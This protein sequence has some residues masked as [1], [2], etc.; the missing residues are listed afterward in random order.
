[1]C[2]KYN[3]E[4]K[5]LPVDF[6]GFN[7]KD[8]EWQNGSYYNLPENPIHKGQAIILVPKRFLRANHNVDE[9]IQSRIKDILSSDAVL[10]NRFSEF[11]SKSISEISTDDIRNIIMKENNVL[12]KYFE[13][14][15]KEDI[16][17]YNFDLDSLSFLSIKKYFDKYKDLKVEPI[18]N[19][20]L[21]GHVFEFIDVF[22]EEVSEMDGWKDMWVF[23]GKKPIR[24]QRE[25]A[26]GRILRGIGL[27]YFRNFKD[28]SFISECGS[29][30]GRLDY[31]VAFKNEKVAIELK[32]VDNCSAAGK[33]GM[34]AYLHGVCKQLPDYIKRLRANFGI[35]L[36]LQH[37][38]KD[39]R[40]RNHHDDRVVEIEN[41]IG[42]I[43]KDI[44]SAI[45][46]FNSLRYVNIKVIP[47]PK[48]SEL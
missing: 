1:M 38:S 46:G 7:F 8:M 22:K 30:N 43:E 6:D 13:L 24:S 42:E 19:G 4:T 47:K 45:R 37:W 44:R 40:P 31:F 35:Y 33:S 3:I 39:N 12:K 10:K 29:G 32:K 15:E 20:E 25:V 21:I 34:P 36:T 5:S 11:L 41:K 26:A 2:K 9:E 23:D 27:A 48:A 28:V 18:K 14:L 16:K 17:P